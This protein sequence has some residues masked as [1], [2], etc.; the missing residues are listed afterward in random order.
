MEYEDYL[1]HERIKKLVIGVT[2]AAVISGGTFALS[3]TAGCG[4]MAKTI[5]SD[6]DNGL[7]RVVY[8]YSMDGD[9][10]AE[11]AGKFDIDS[12]TERI[13]FD[14]EY[15]RRHQI[16]FG[17]GIA[18][19]DEITEEELETIKSRQDM[20]QIT[21]TKVYTYLPNEIEIHKTL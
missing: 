20:S 5:H 19:I 12:N 13:I 18:I 11:Y 8:V 4:R 21:G 16:Y 15:N 14:D 7:N 2:I 10:M 9:L 6:F 3:Q 17:Y 1:R